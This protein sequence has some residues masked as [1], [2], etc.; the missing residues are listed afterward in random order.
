MPPIGTKCIECGDRDGDLMLVK[1]MESGSG[2]GAGLYA[3]R[4][5]C[6]PAIAGRSY[7]PDWLSKELAEQGLWPPAN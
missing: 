2:P 5:T 4:T 6:A 1:I 7:A 3:C